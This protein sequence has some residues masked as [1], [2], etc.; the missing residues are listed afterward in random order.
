MIEN[1]QPDGGYVLG[2]GDKRIPFRIEYRRR[3]NLA[4]SVHPELRLEVVAPEGSTTDQVLRRVEKRAGWILR[5]W[6]YFEQFL[7]THPGPRY[8]SGE[9]HLYLGR[10]YRLK[11]HEGSPSRVKLVGRFLHVWTSD[12]PNGDDTSH[13]L[14]HWYREH[15]QRVFGQRLRHCLERCPSLRCPPELSITIRKMTHRWGSCTKAG[16]LLLNLEL[17]KVPIHC[18]DY[19]LVHE[20]CHLQIHNHSPDFYRLLSRCMPDWRKRK[21]RLE[22]FAAL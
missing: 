3:K 2:F 13:L 11:V 5:Q 19:V 17:I 12:L 21:E 6:R 8:V 1:S 18:V 4:I 22:E 9:T 14:L 20:L 16:N 15:A 7:P 10:Q